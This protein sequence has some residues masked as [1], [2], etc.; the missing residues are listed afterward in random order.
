MAP[1]KEWFGGYNVIFNWIEEKYGYDAL[2]QYW[3][4][5]AESCFGDIKGISDGNELTGLK[6]Y[7][8]CTFA[9]DD[10]EYV[11]EIIDGKLTFEI[12][13]CPDYQFMLSSSNPYFKPIK[14]YCRHHEVINSVIAEKAG[15][16]FCMTECN[17]NGACKWIFE[18][19]FEK[20]IE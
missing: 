4:F 12:K 10:G 14:N 5:I 18:K 1:I 13:K 9:K 7:Y 6:D 15:C 2:E 8:E 19:K 3:R 16:S 20:G 11:S 17:N